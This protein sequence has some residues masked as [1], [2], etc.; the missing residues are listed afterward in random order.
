MFYSEQI[1]YKH[2][3]YVNSYARGYLWVMMCILELVCKFYVTF[4]VLIVY[5]KYV[6]DD[7]KVD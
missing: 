5:F 6:E 1:S 7:I 4:V 3:K 2:S